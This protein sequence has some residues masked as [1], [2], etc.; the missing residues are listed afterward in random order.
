MSAND[1]KDKICLK[2]IA[3]K[4]MELMREIRTTTSESLASML[5]QRLFIENQNMNAH[6]TVKRRIYDVI[7]VLSAAGIIEKV[8]KKLTWHGLNDFRNLTSMQTNSPTKRPPSAASSPNPTQS[9]MDPLYQFPLNASVP[10]LPSPQ[11]IQQ[12]QQNQHSLE[13]KEKKLL[14]KIKTLAI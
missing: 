8:G 3:P 10:R 1:T 4:L 12:Q 2:S 6:D 13:E 7:N 9:C 11:R 14:I 5:I